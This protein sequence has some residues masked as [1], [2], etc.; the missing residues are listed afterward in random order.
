VGAHRAAR[1]AYY[2]C[3]IDILPR[4]THPARLELGVSLHLNTV[5]PDHAAA[6]LRE[7]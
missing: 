5:A 3:R 6:Q 4:L 1:A 7:L 2:G